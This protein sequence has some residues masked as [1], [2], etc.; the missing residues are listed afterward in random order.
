MFAFTR[1]VQ[2]TSYILTLDVFVSCTYAER[3]VLRAR[4]PNGLRFSVSYGLEYPVHTKPPIPRAFM[5]SKMHVTPGPSLRWSVWKR[6][7]AV[8][9]VTGAAVRV[10][11][12]VPLPNL[13]RVECPKETQRFA[14]NRNQCPVAQRATRTRTH[15]RAGTL[16]RS[17]ARLPTGR[18]PLPGL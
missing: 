5:S 10:K 4:S 15:T 17:L 18:K 1:V 7:N 11:N 3:I 12:H 16:T 13:S 14:C 2:Y 6:L 9:T 8:Q